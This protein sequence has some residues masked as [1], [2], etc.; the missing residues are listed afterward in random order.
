MEDLNINNEDILVESDAAAYTQPSQSVPQNTFIEDELNTNNAAVPTFNIL[1]Y[2]DDVMG[3]EGFRE[4]AY[5]DAGGFSIGYGERLNP[6]IANI[7]RGQGYIDDYSN[8]PTY[9]G[10]ADLLVDEN[11]SGKLLDSKLVQSSNEAERIMGDAWGGLDDTAKFI[12]SDLVYNMG[13]SKFTDKEKGF[14]KF[15]Q[16]MKDKEWALAAEELKWKDKDKNVLSKYYTAGGLAPKG[17]DR[18]DSH[19]YMLENLAKGMP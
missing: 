8:E 6:T 16:A 17:T 14:P 18:A 5:P 10:F 2:R 4:R 19:I 15:I 3:F 9:L 13:L 1:D 11:I 7:L 12:M